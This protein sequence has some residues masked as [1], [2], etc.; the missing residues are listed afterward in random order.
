MAANANFAATPRTSSAVLTTANTDRT[1]V[2]TTGMQDLFSPGASGSRVDDITVAC[3]G[4]STAGAVAFFMSD[5]AGT[6]NR[7]LFELLVPAI[8][9][10]TTVSPF[11]TTLRDLGIMV[12]TGFKLRVT[13][14]VAASGANDQFQA[15]VIKAGDF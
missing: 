12:P 15:V 5:T 6:T 1:G 7:F 11:M 4:N 3:T 8:T 9:T 10:S 14:R 13:S 2:T